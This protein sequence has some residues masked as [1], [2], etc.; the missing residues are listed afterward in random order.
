MTNGIQIQV[1]NIECGGCEKFMIRGLSA[2][3]DLSD[4]VINRDAQTTTC[5]APESLRHLVVKKLC[6]MGYPLRGKPTGFNAGL[7]SV[8]SFIGCAVG[9]DS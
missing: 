6:A 3:D 1:E 2:V 7:A 5:I 4:I 8:K 9:Q